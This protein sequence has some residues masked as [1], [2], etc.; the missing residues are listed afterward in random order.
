MVEYALL[1]LLITLTLSIA[2]VAAAVVVRWKPGSASTRT[3]KP[4]PSPETTQTSVTPAAL[5]AMQ[6]DQVALFSTLEKL[7]TSMKRLSSRS[8]MREL[9]EREEA[10]SNSDPPAGTSKAE[11]LRHYGMAGKVGPAF[12]EAQQQLEFRRSNNERTN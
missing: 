3:P 6:A 8:G 7:T 2:S 5:A 11:L 12:A 4:T 10:G 9:R 1:C